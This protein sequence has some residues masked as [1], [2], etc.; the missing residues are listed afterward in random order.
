MSI[1]PSSRFKGGAKAMPTGRIAVARQKMMIMGDRPSCI[2]RSEMIPLMGAPKAM[3][4]GNV[5]MASTMDLLSKPP[6]C[7]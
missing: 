7:P 4:I 5:T 6:T 1:M 3:S 2:Q